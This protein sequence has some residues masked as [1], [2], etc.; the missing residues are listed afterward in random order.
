MVCCS[1]FCVKE[2]ALFKQ[3]ASWDFSKDPNSLVA[4]FIA[5]RE[6]EETCLRCKKIETQAQVIE[7][8]QLVFYELWIK[9]GWTQMH[10]EI[11]DKKNWEELMKCQCC[12]CLEK[13]KG[14]TWNRGDMVD[15]FGNRSHLIVSFYYYYD[16]SECELFQRCLKRK[17]ERKKR[18]IEYSLFKKRYFVSQRGGLNTTR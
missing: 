8:P 14:Y 12:L 7:R 11:A 15:N 6:T 2:Y 9:E 3:L 10:I 18:K 16:P 5:Q 17:H 1:K 4:G 13:K